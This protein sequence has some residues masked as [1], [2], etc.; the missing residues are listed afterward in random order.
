MKKILK[1]SVTV[2]LLVAVVAGASVLYNKLSSQYQGGNLVT[3][4]D[5]ISSQLGGAQPNAGGNVNTPPENNNTE[6]GDSGE[7]ENGTE[8]PPESSSGSENEPENPSAN[9]NGGNAPENGD[10]NTNTEP[11]NGDSG[12]SS[13]PENGG[14]E[15]KEEQETPEPPKNLA[16]DFTVLD[17]NGNAVKLSDFR[18]KP[19]VLNFWATWCGYCIREMPDFNTAYSKYPEIQFLMVNAT[20]NSDTVEKAKKAKA[21]NGYNFDIFF[22]TAGEAVNAYNVTGFPTTYFISAEGELI[23]VGRGM[24]NM[25]TIEQGI[26]MILPAKKED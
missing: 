25:A 23:A 1:L 4:Q 13:E 20:S 14:E 22:D 2:V 26:S 5:L 18:G 10:N 15:E 8:N 21:D 12:T 19:V 16:P 17:E 11:E 24:L 7:P 3:D 6:I 9:E